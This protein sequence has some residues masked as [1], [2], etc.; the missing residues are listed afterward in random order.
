M[1]VLRVRKKPVEVQAMLFDGTK[2]RAV[3]IHQWSDGKAR[4][5][6]RDHEWRIEVECLDGN[7][8]TVGPGDYVMLGVAGEFYPCRADVFAATYDVLQAK[9]RW[10][11]PYCLACDR[12]AGAG[13]QPE[14]GHDVL[15]VTVCDDCEHAKVQC[16]DCKER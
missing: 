5:I 14:R 6:A 13:C 9:R 4:G 12:W 11:K 16:D 2:D 7:L 8:A 1:T 15:N 3:A 10:S